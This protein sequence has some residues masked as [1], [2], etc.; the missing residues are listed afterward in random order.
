ME[1]REV[2]IVTNRAELAE[3]FARELRRVGFEVCAAPTVEA[4]AAAATRGRAVAALLDWDIPSIDGCEAFRRIR[5]QNPSLP[6]VLLGSHASEFDRVLGLEVGA[7][8]FIGKPISA[9]EMVARLKA[10]LRRATL[11]LRASTRSAAYGALKI[12]FDKREVQVDE[13]KIDLSATEFDILSVLA[14]KPGHVFSRSEIISCV[15]GFGADSYG[16]N[17]TAHINRM[18]RKIEMHGHR[19]RFVFTVRGIGYRFITREE[20]F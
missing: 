7:D 18:R 6:I 20:L 14:G 16:E 5:D 19:F 2:V 3:D 15:W 1:R 17:V 13:K 9:L 4:G 10:I 11:P 12:D 8:D